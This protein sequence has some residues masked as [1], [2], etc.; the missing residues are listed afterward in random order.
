MRAPSLPER[1]RLRSL[2]VH[3][4]ILGAF[5]LLESAILTASLV[6]IH[7]IHE[8]GV[9]A[10]L[11]ADIALA[12]AS[13]DSLIERSERELVRSLRLLTRDPA[14]MDALLN[15]ADR[16]L[17]RS[18]LL[19]VNARLGTRHLALT[20]GRGV[21]RASTLPFEADGVRLDRIPHLRRALEGDSSSGIVSLKRDFILA[22]VPITARGRLL[23]VI[24]AVSEIDRAFAEE[25][26]RMTGFDVIFSA[27][28]ELRASTLASSFSE[29][30]ARELL[31]LRPGR[32]FAIAAGSGRYIAVGM[33]L[34]P[35]VRLH[36]LKSWESAYK[37]LRSSQ[38][39][40]T[41]IGL[42]GLLGTALA[43][44]FISSGLT[45]SIAALIDRLRD[46]NEQLRRL[47]EFKSKFFSLVAHDVKNPLTAIELSAHML[48]KLDANIAAHN[49]VNV[50]VRSVRS[51][52]F[53]ISDLVD[54]AAME[55]GKLRVQTAPVDL[56]HILAEIKERFE[57][58]AR[59]KEIDFFV[60]SPASMP[61]VADGPRI[62]QVLQNLCANAVSYSKPGGKV[63][64]RAA[65]DGY[66]AQVSVEDS[67][68]GIAEED[69]SRIFEPFFQAENAKQ[70]RSGGFGLGLKIAREIVQ[71]HGGELGVRSRLGSGSTFFFTLPLTAQ[72]TTPG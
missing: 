67:G 7:K 39:T 60:E 52:N 40:L 10:D 23:G 25:L 58:L 4:Q 24:I 61:L 47:D 65:T 31:S 26:K 18:A 36:V 14:F 21:L 3:V 56:S 13:M 51:L 45:A 69:I 12:R 2:P 9:N 50:I 46:S 63:W 49:S 35:V 42:A 27:R 33:D 59:R 64:L 1:G 28:G 17:S 41:A 16:G 48:T 5:L 62:T 6:A 11:G 29:A 66:A 15:V 38:R 68:I 44:F 30:Q 53:I 57:P 54:F 20:D 32:A 19:D 71:A 34:S 8:R 22:A 37:R 72:A 70:V 43:G 55:N